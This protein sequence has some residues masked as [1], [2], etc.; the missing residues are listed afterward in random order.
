M[1]KVVDTTLL[2]T[3]RHSYMRNRDPPLFVNLGHVWL[4]LFIVCYEWRGITICTHQLLLKFS[5]FLE[6]VFLTKIFL[7][8]DI[9]WPSQKFSLSAFVSRIKSLFLR[10]YIWKYYILLFITSFNKLF[11]CIKKYIFGYYLFL[12][13]LLLL[14]L[15]LL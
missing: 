2:F 11:S 13:K 10:M 5:T 1:K 9:P 7:I 14:L 6:N 12:G 4:T 3:T 15:L 8:F